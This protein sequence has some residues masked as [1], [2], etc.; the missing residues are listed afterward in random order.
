MLDHPAV[1]RNTDRLKAD[2]YIVL[3]PMLGP[4][5]ATREHMDRIG[6]GFPMPTLLLQMQAL[7]TDP[8]A[9]RGKPNRN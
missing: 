3:P 2:G 5:V 9:G 1:Q 7:L 6:E 4:E 8:G